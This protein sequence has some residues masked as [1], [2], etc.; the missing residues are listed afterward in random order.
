MPA[1]FN[2]QGVMQAIKTGDRVRIDGDRGTVERLGV[3][4]TS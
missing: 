4:K 3:V 2:V 1:V